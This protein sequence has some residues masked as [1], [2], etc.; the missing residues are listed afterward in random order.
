V[1]S[2]TDAAIS[3]RTKAGEQHHD[4]HTATPLLSD[5]APLS[6][7]Y[8]PTD[9]RRLDAIVAPLRAWVS[10]R[11]YG[12]ENIPAEGPV[13]LVGNHSMVPLDV[14]LLNQELRRRYGRVLRGLGDDALMSPA[15]IRRYVQWHGGVRGSR[16]NCLDLL[17][18][19]EMILVLPGGTREALRLKNERYV[20]K[21]DR[22]IGF[23]RMAIEAGVPIVPIAMV[24]ANDAY[25]VI[26]DGQ[27][28]L[29]APLRRY[30]ERQP[31]P[32]PAPPLFRGL[33]PTLIPKPKRF[34]FSAGSPI[35][36]AQWRDTDDRAAEL[37]R[38]VRAGLEKEF[39]FLFA[40]RA[41][42][43]GRSLWGRTRER[44]AGN[45]S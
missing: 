18:H 13:M 24:G 19:G 7:S 42:D 32:N 45:K 3:A 9:V 39:A 2:V 10:P 37:Q 14:Y 17:A 34:Y 40:E 35:D 38:V 28:P 5:G 27:H 1:T 8:T 30:G 11:F 21:W 16:E 44:W 22:R 25:D 43:R 41:Q 12:L 15:F 31:R 4:G 23:A 6:I 36:A 26:I 20:L 33:G 29:M